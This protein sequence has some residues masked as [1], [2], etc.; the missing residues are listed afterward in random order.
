[1]KTLYTSLCMMF[2][3]LL[4]VSMSAQTRQ[5]AVWARTVPAGTITLDGVLNEAAWAKAESLQITY[6]VQGLLPTSGWRPEFQPE[7]ITDPTHATV[8]FL[9]QGNVLYLSFFIPDS[10]IGGTADWARWD[11]ILMS[12]KNKTGKARPTP[13]AEYFYTYWLAGLP[14]GT[15]VVGAQPRFVGT[16]GNFNDTVRT[17][18]QRAAWDAKTSFDG[19][20]N[21]GLRDKS[22]TVEMKCDLG[23]LGYDVTQTNGDVV[24]LNF[25]IWDADYLFET[26]PM[27]I[28]SART[29]WQ[30]PWGNTNADNVGRIYAR[31]DVTVNTTSLPVIKADVVVENGANYAAPVIDGKPYEEVWHHAEMFQIAWEDTNNTIRSTYPGIGP[32]LSGQWQPELITGLKPPVTDPVNAKI[33]IFYRDNNL[34][35]SADVK[36]K[37]VQGTEIYDKY[38]GINF[39]VADRGKFND[40]N[41]ITFK[42]LRVGWGLNGVATAYDDLPSY[43]DTGAVE[44]KLA[45]K[46]KTTIGNNNDVDSGYTCEMRIDLTKIGYPSNLGD[47]LVFMGICV[48]DG[49]SFVDSVKNYGTR[50]WWFRE[51]DGGPSSPWMV[52]DPTALVAVE[53]E[54]PGMLPKT[55]ELAGNYPNPFNPTTNIRYSLPYSGD[56]TIT[57]FNM[58]GEVLYTQKVMSV[59]AGKHDFNFN[60]AG[61]ASGAYFYKISLSG[62]KNVESMTGK[63]LLLK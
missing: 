1:M 5:D 26:N 52:L 35:I 13:A 25:S 60:A 7:A 57:V 31:P 30:S 34:Y 8:K 28:R 3:L 11:A 40:A 62:E 58:L 54:N 56:V 33:K 36:D 17:P 47:K 37:I 4:N 10:S 29:H 50:S 19:I 48:G 27:A 53:K 43:V 20:A 59:S 41:M 44:W 12:L 24:P 2:I 6:G 42:K 14:S 45:L 32:L 51:H 9:V 38:D 39:S 63:M 21:D 46:G 49:D 55:I 16:Y 23:V 18:E 15:P 61:I 22:W